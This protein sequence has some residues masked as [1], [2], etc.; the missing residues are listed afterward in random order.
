MQDS[1]P[2]E[3]CR[4]SLS[5][6]N[7]LMQKHFEYIVIGSGIAGLFAALEATKYGSVIVLTKGSIQDTNT[8]LAQGGI[9]AAIGKDDS[10]EI[11][12]QD[13][14]DAGAGLSDREAVNVLT[15]EGPSR[16]NDLIKMGVSFDEINGRIALALEGA[17]ARPRVLHAGGDATGAH[18][19]LTLAHLAQTSNIDVLEY[20]LVTSIKVESGRAVGVEVLDS[21]S[22][23][24]TQFTGSN[25]I[26]ATGGAGQLFKSTTNPLVATGDGV[27]L[28][29]NA[30]AEL[31]GMEF[32]Q[33]HPT[34]L[35]LP[36]IR[37]FLISEAVR[38]EGARLVNRKGDFFMHRYHEKLDLAPRDVVSRAI[39]NEMSES[40]SEYVLLDLS[41]I[42]KSTRMSRF[43][44]I[45]QVCMDYGIDITKD[46]IPI[47]PAAHYM[48]GGVR[49]NLWGQTTIP[50]LYAC[51]EVSSTG[52]H[53]ANRL[54]SNSLLETVVFARR[55]IENST[56]P[57]SANTF[58]EKTN[59]AIQLRPPEASDNK[60]NFTKELVQE[61][62]MDN[63]GIIKNGTDLMKAADRLSS[64]L[65]SCIEPNNRSSH[66]LSNMTLVGWLMAEAS[67]IRK[68]SR[69]AH[70]RSDY[71]KISSNWAENIILRKSDVD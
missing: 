1:N 6:E 41:L 50:G 18:M 59:Q 17:H 23:V 24:K 71:P 44:T 56:R 26:L 8:L 25:V 53:G 36:G 64:I 35:F 15:S 7:S 60:I 14:I 45:Y 62:M 70:F 34:A 55:V 2:E 49:T 68:E 69:G 48:M 27:A 22:Y 42:N 67:L 16:I 30:G 5:K 65:K 20:A 19:E 3:D 51:G 54:A 13:T 63:V 4:V 39:I 37:P 61:L 11:H 38:G 66:E 47:A 31:T 12:M 9:A 33:F 21:Q 43:P 28:G 57:L 29:F 32:Y 10:P 52:V 46:M 58:L 40:N